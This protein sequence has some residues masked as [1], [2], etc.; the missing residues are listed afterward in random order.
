MNAVHRA[1]F[2]GSLGVAGLV[3]FGLP[4]QSHPLF[5]QRHK[6]LSSG[7]EGQLMTALLP[8]KEAKAQ[9]PFQGLELPGQGGL[10][11]KQCLCRP[12]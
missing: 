8:L 3:K 12:R 11:D 10:G 7:G 6:F 9:L 5:G 2:Q 1:D 4:V